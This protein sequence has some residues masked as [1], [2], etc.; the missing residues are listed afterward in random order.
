MT[1]K[2]AAAPVPEKPLTPEEKLAAREAAREREALREARRAS[3][4]FW[5]KTVCAAAVAAACFFGAGR[6]V[7]YVTGL[8]VFTFSTLEVTGD[9][10]R[11][12]AARVKEAVEP[13][14]RGNFFTADLSAVRRA[15]EEVAWVRE[16]TVRRVWPNELQIGVETH[17]ALALYEDGRLVSTEGVLFAAN[18]DERDNP[19]DPLPNFYGPAAQVPQIARYWREFSLALRPLGVTVTDVNCSDRGSWSLVMSSDDIPP[20]R[21][22]LGQEEAGVSV[23][24]RLADMAAAYPKVAELM[25]G[26]PSSLDLRYNRAFA[27]ALP[28]RDA[29]ERLI[30][31]KLSGP[32]AAPETPE[33]PEDTEIP[34]KPNGNPE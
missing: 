26:P 31:Q 9:I 25:D 22:E 19:S 15:V 29:I 30:M 12:P 23:V 34:D 28:D 11:V 16:A 18:P 20:T 24:E 5:T 33:E 17:Q 3:L 27:A 6:A 14:L 21:V 8:P 10:V 13:A 1:K 7:N 32:D 2:R 4:R